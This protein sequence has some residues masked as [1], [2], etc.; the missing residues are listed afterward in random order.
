VVWLAILSDDLMA[1][2]LVSR[3]AEVI[4]K[5]STLLLTEARMDALSEMADLMDSLMDVLTA[6]ADLKDS[7]MGATM[8]SV[9]TLLHSELSR[10]P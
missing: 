1:K 4:S 3:L 8:Y 2:W 7:Q 5:H 9:K 10:S 6:T